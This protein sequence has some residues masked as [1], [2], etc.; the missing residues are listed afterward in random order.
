MASSLA[1][2][3]EI[4]S[5]TVMATQQMATPTFNI[6]VAEWVQR[7][8]PLKNFLDLGNKTT[9]D[10]L[11]KLGDVLRNN[12]PKVVDDVTGFLADTIFMQALCSSTKSH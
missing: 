4:T 11:T 2:L 3:T 6:C 8:N 5:T 12:G 1:V 9:I 7:R 10:N